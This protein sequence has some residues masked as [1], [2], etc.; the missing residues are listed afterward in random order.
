MFTIVHLHDYHSYKVSKT[1]KIILVFEEMKSSNISYNIYLKI[2][3]RILLF[4]I[5]FDEK[6][7]K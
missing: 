4:L 3:T 7:M 2:Y 6:K 1:T 5:V